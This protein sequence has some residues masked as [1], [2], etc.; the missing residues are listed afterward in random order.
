M[1]HLTP[2]ILLVGSLF[3]AHVVQANPLPPVSAPEAGFSS[4]GLARIDKFF[5]RETQA[6]RV[7]GAV[8]AIAR[9]GKLVYYKAYGHLDKPKGTPIPRDAIFALASMT[10]IMASVAALQLTQEGRLPLK[11]QLSNYFPNLP[12]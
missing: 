12:R 10:K 4:E 11:S 9:D 2:L 5:D 6:N 3:A 7:P 1:K 8:I